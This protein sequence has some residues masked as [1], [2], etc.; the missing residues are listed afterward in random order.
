MQET[1]KGD[2]AKFASLGPRMGSN[3]SLLR[4]PPEENSSGLLGGTSKGNYPESRK[5]EG[6]NPNRNRP[7]QQCLGRN[8]DREPKAAA[9]LRRELGPGKEKSGSSRAWQ[10]GTGTVGV[11]GDTSPH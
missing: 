4:L 5:A 6:K 9:M 8:R 3:Q 11:G 2:P 10:I 7:G 1:V